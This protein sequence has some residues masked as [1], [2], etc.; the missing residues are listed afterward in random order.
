MQLQ[1][2]RGVDEQREADRVTL[3]EAERGERLDLL[4]D[5][6]GQFAGDALGGHPVV[7]PPPQRVDAF[8]GPLGPHGPA[9]LVGLG[10]REA[11]G[12]HGDLHELF[13]EQRDAQRP[14][15]SWFQALVRE[16]DLLVAPLAPDVG[17]YRVALDRSGPDQRH[18][19]GQVV[20]PLR[21]QA[22]QG[23][24][25][26]TGLDLEHPYAVGTSEHLVDAGHLLRDGVE[27]VADAVPVADQFEAVLQ[28]REHAQAE[29]VELDQADRRA[30]VL[31]PLQHGAIRHPPPL[32]RADLDDRTVADHHPAGVDAQMPRGVL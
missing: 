15:E 5:L 18:L 4:V 32:D 21:A 31:V 22:R 2:G 8:D 24:H 30:V 23:G 12:V 16:G 26:G 19:D 27:V 20:E 29:Q 11:G 1:P 17:V 14:R 7:E 3:G 13:L 28:R 10:G 25:L 9:Q 6:V